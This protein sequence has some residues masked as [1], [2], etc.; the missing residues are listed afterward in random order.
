MYK[1]NFYVDSK[2]NRPI[3]D[4]IN[5]LKKK[6]DKNSRINYEKIKMVVS[7]LQNYGLDLGMPYI[8][9]IDKDIWELRPIR[10]RI[11]FFEYRN[12]E[13]VLLHMFLKKTNKTPKKEIEI[14][15]KR[16]NTVIEGEKNNEKQEK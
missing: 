3:N 14:A 9:K 13:F 5:S 15:R 7:L 4:Y 1:I 12:N 2:G 16:M 11:L 10:N 6:K 8:K